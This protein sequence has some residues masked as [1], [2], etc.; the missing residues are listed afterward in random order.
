M[1]NRG[2]FQTIIW[3]CS[4]AKLPIF[5]WSLP[6]LP[7]LLKL[8][9][10][11][12]PFP[13]IRR[14]RAEKHRNVFATRNYRGG[15]GGFPGDPLAEARE[16]RPVPRDNEQWDEQIR[17]AERLVEDPRKMEFEACSVGSHK[18]ERSQKKLFTSLRRGTSRH[19]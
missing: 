8:K 5:R 7:P 10:S 17:I 6:P 11:V 12:S 16:S 15:G 14:E 3:S 19:G 2:G 4:R 1:A 9:L 18:R 13:S